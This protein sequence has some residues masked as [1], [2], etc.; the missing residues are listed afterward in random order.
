M[1]N[2]MEWPAEYYPLQLFLH[3]KWFPS[4][5]SHP[6]P[7]FFFF[8]FKNVWY[9]SGC[10]DEL[11][12]GFI[13]VLYVGVIALTACVDCRFWSSLRAHVPI[14]PVLSHSNK[15]GRLYCFR[16]NNIPLLTDICSVR[17]CLCSCIALIRYNLYNHPVLQCIN[18]R[19]IIIIML[20][21][22]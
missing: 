10:R 5:F 11:T 1:A 22:K 13:S 9:V 18:W 21:H 15:V 8:F 14:D 17:K 6:E 19:K 20:S 2:Y 7:R 12:E 3:M 4:S 16:I